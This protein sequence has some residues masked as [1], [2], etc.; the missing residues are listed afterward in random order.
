MANKIKFLTKLLNMVGDKIASMDDIC[1]PMLDILQALYADDL[2]VIPRNTPE[3]PAEAYKSND[4]IKTVKTVFI[5]TTVTSIGKNA[6]RTCTNLAGLTIP[7]SVITIDDDAFAECSE[8]TILTLSDN[9]TKVNRGICYYCTALTDIIIPDNV[10]EI[11]TYAF[12][13]CTSLKNVT[14]GEKVETIGLQ[15]FY[16]CSK[17]ESIVVNENNE[18]FV[19]IDG[20]LYEYNDAASTTLTL[21][22]YATG[23]AATEFTIPSNVTTIGHS[24][25]AF[26]KNLTSIII[27]ESVTTIDSLAFNYCTNLI[28]IN[29]AGSESN[30]NKIVKNNN[31]NSNIT[32]TINYNYT[33]N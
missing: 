22:Q 13:N 7:N 16:S 23:K 25:F 31:W 30:W 19:A 12:F 17:L 1:Y 18:H 8:L 24:A 32:A 9:I 3:I 2:L 28:S 10:T 33:S 6:F 20:N 11:D 4:K 15:V 5:P 29:Y 27:P 21:R 26:C 14:I